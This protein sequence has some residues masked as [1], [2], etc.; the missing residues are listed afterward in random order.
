MLARHV[1]GLAELFQRL[2]DDGVQAAREAG[3]GALHRLGDKRR[4]GIIGHGPGRAGGD[5]LPALGL[6]DVDALADF[7]A[8][9]IFQ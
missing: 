4:D 6:A 1:L 8:D 3:Q 7:F 5:E 9:E 2:V